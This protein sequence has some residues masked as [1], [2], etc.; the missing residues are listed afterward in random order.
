MRYWRR[1][2]WQLD[3]QHQEIDQSYKVPFRS[4]LGDMDGGMDAFDTVNSELR[5]RK[6]EKRGM[7]M[8]A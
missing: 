2:P 7:R 3:I 8:H 4:P 6:I 5:M 1:S